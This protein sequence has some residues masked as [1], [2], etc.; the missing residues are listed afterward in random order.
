MWRRWF[1][2]LVRAVATAAAGM[3]VCV[4]SKRLC[5]IFTAINVCCGL[6]KYHGYIH[7]VKREWRVFINVLYSIHTY[8]R[9]LS[10]ASSLS[11]SVYNI[12]AQ[13]QLTCT[14][15]SAKPNVFVLRIGYTR[16]ESKKQRTNDAS[17]VLS[18]WLASTLKVKV[19]D[20][21]LLA[22]VY[23]YV[24]TLAAVAAVST[25]LILLA[26]YVCGWSCGSR[27]TYVYDSSSL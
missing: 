4:I 9:S 6:P 7:V 5:P 23:T 18:R 21:W 10:L 25:F 19:T 3:C 27:Q 11:V 26:L 22:T 24:Y 16:E 13:H 20:L 14:L 1:A 12:L 2:K 15:W 8:T 17:K